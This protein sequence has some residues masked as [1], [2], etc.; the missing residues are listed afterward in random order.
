[1]TINREQQI[2][3]KILKEI[4]V[5][6]SYVLQ[7]YDGSEF[8]SKSIYY[9]DIEDIRIIFSVYSSKDNIVFI[10]VESVG[11]NY[12]WEIMDLIHYIRNKTNKRT[13]NWY[14]APYMQSFGTEKQLV[15]MC[16]IFRVYYGAIKQY[17]HCN[18]LTLEELSRQKYDK[19]EKERLLN[20]DYGFSDF[21]RKS[22][23]KEV[24]KTTEKH[25]DG[26]SPTSK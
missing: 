13:R 5:R 9:S 12:F 23:Y 24:K 21:G 20:T 26:R 14:G 10:E 1:M 11:K 17:L 19:K 18:N 3:E 8:N 7:S 4:F 2:I 22:K 25:N 16:K 15:Y 6:D